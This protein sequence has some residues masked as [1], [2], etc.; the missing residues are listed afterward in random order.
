[1]QIMPYAQGHA[2]LHSLEWLQLNILS[3]SNIREDVEL[4]YTLVQ[5]ENTKTEAYTFLREMKP[6]VHKRP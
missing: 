6:F 4:S 3:K 2:I 5:S 1:M